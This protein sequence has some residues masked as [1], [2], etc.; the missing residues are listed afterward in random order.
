M[1]YCDKV[2]IVVVGYNKIVGLKRL[3]E[4][5]NSLN[6]CSCDIP[7]II[8]I[9][10]SGN[11]DVYDYVSKYVWN[12]GLK[13]LNIEKSRLG[14]KNHIFQCAALSQYFKGVIILE[15]D[16]LVAPD[17]Y[18]FAVSA[19]EK[20]GQDDRIAGIALYSFETNL[21]AKLPFVPIQNGCD[22]FAWQNVCTW[23]Q[24]FTWRMWRPFQDWLKQWDEK[25]ESVD[26]M[27]RIKSWEKAW[28]K[29]YFAYLL[30]N[31]KYFIYP[32]VSLSTNFNDVGGE[33]GGGNASIVQVSLLQGH[34]DYALWD[35]EDMEK[36]DVFLQNKS[37]PDWLGLS[38]SDLTVDLFGLREVY[39]TRF[40]LAPFKLPY[41]Q[42][43]SF[44]LSMRP[45]ELN[46]KYDIPGSDL[47]LYDRE[48]SVCCISPVREFH[49]GVA[50]YYLRGFN[51][52]LLTKYYWNNF[53]A[54]VRNKLRIN[55]R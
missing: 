21:Y 1:E 47:I 33:H 34:K 22:V 5:L 2:A 7:L 12:H 30:L 52:R 38:S 48:Q 49:L 6:Y 14:L 53:K 46:I 19:L 42:K 55:K 9:D 54:R 17:F 15:D 8:S 26:M 32:Y 24:L 51:I 10:A 11:Q 37:I 44:S 45:I 16:I 43:K 4:T 27:K 23:G 36:Y 29:Y 39:D 25:F 35:F 50:D 40:I 18:N 41:K 20:Y 31:N 28:S 13:Y 3:L